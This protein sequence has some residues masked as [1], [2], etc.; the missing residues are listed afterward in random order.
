MLSLNF[1]SLLTVGLC[2]GVGLGPVRA[3]LG[4]G[5]AFPV[6]SEARL[7]GVLPATAGRL[8]LVDFWASWCAPCQASFPALARLHADYAARGVTILGVSVDEKAA[9]SAAFVKRLAPPFA[10]VR[11][12][13]HQL[14]AAVNVSAMPS[15]FLVGRDGR[16][17]AV[18]AGYH[19]N[20]TE[21]AIRAALDQAL[22]E[23]SLP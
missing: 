4:R 6:L 10:T 17:R 8:V 18:F 3:E 15:T 20:E 5:A 13:A 16:V 14:V 19:G 9:A 2:F 22:A 23:I 11:D 1:R 21:K 7:E 12:P